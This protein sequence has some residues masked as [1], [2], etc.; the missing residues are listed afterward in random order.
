LFDETADINNAAF[1]GGG[2]LNTNALPRDPARGGALVYPHNYLRV[3]TTFEVVK[4]AGGHTAWIDKHLSD[5]IVNGPSGQ[6]VED[7]WTPESAAL[8]PPTGLVNINKSVDASIWNDNLKV[9][10]IVNQ[11]GDS[12]I[13]A[14]TSGVRSLRHEP[15][16][17]WR[18]NSRRITPSPA[19]TR[20]HL[21][22]WRL[23]RWLG[24]PSMNA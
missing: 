2:G 16:L 14:A 23:P 13:L 20:P 24:T 21:S 1:D 6:G 7:L 15:Q 18:K 12:T 3:N 10:A 8:Y 5:E 17:V 4:A 11:I 9:Q 22:D 19:G